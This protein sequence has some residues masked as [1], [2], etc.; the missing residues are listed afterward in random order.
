VRF[1]RI[2]GFTGIEA[3]RDDA[4]RGSLRVVEG[5]LPHGPGGLRSGPVWEKIGEAGNHSSSDSNYISAADDGNGNSLIM[6]SRQ[7]EFRDMVLSSTE[8][9]EIESFQPSYDV[10][11]PEGSIYSLDNAPISSIGNRLYAVGDG[12]DEAIYLGKGP[13]QDG[14]FAVRPDV[15]L[16]R[17][18]WSRF[19]KCKFFARGPKGSLFGAGNPDKPL[20][21]YISEPP[22]ISAPLRDAPYSTEETVYNAGSLSTVEILVSDATKITALSTRGDQVVV[23]TNKGSFL[24]YAP[25]GDQ[26]NTGYRVE[27]VPATN[28]SAAV[29]HQVVAGESGTQTYWIGHDGQVYKDEAASRGAADL[30]SV[31]D[32]DQANWKSKG[33]WEIEIPT[34]I[35]NSFATFEGQTGNYIF[36]L[37]EKNYSDEFSV[38]LAPLNGQSSVEVQ[39]NIHWGIKIDRWNGMNLEDCRWNRKKSC[40]YKTNEPLFDPDWT[41][42]F[43]Y[44]VFATKEEAVEFIGSRRTCCTSLCCHDDYLWGANRND[45]FCDPHNPDNGAPE[46]DTH[47]DCAA[48]IRDDETCENWTYYDCGCYRDVEG[49]VHRDMEERNKMYFGDGSVI[50]KEDPPVSMPGEEACYAYRM[51][52]GCD[53]H[54]LIPLSNT[55]FECGCEPHPSG[56][57]QSLADCQYD[58]EINLSRPGYECFSRYELNYQSCE[59]EENYFGTYATY[60]A[61]ETDNYLR[62]KK[63]DFDSCDP[64]SLNK[65]ECYQTDEGPYQGVDVCNQARSEECQ[66]YDFNC[67]DG[68]QPS[69]NGPFVSLTQCQNEHDVVCRNYTF[70]GCEIGCVEGT[71]HIENAGIMNLYTCTE[72]YNTYCQMHGL[73]V[74]TDSTGLD[75]ECVPDVSGGYLNLGICEEA[76]A[77]ECTSYSLTDCECVQDPDGGFDTLS[78]CEAAKAT[79][80]Q[81][82]DLNSC[83]CEA[84][85]TDAGA[86]DTLSDCEVAKEL[87]CQA[88]SLT[89]CECIPDAVGVFPNLSSCELS[90]HIEC[91]SY[92]L[93]EC[94]CVAEEGGAFETKTACEEQKIID[95]SNYSLNNCECVIDNANGTYSSLAECETAKQSECQRYNLNSFCECVQDPGGAYSTL[96]EC[97][98]VSL[99]TC[100]TYDINRDS[101]ECVPNYS[102]TGKFSDSYACNNERIEKCARHGIDDCCY[103]VHDSFG[104]F[105]NYY[106]CEESLAIGGKYENCDPDYTWNKDDAGCCYELDNCD[107]SGGYIDEASCVA[108]GGK[109]EVNETYCLTTGG[110]ASYDVCN[111]KSTPQD[112]LRYCGGDNPE[113]PDHCDNCPELVYVLSD[114]G[115][116]C[117]PTLS[118]ES[119][120]V[121]GYIIAHE[122]I[123]ECSMTI[124]PACAGYNLENCT[125][126]QTA[127]GSGTYTGITECEQA[128][129]ADQNCVTWNL[130]EGTCE[131]V[132]VTGDVGQ[133]MSQAECETAKSA[134]N[135][136]GHYWIDA[137]TCSCTTT[138]PNDGNPPFV[139]LTNCDN[140]LYAHECM[141]GG[142]GGGGCDDSEYVYQMFED[143]PG[144]LVCLNQYSYDETNNVTE[145]TCEAAGA[146]IFN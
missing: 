92:N 137:N 7:C 98:A 71:E 106:Q 140:A 96:S 60:S 129:D 75:C 43:L 122:T 109:T 120:I 65:G 72:Y 28:F 33:V 34:D 142:G 53:P 130:D 128:R 9:V 136:C 31:A 10:M 41:T 67:T 23:H 91:Q 76:L 78:L 121:S 70:G 66:N 118:D 11:I 14:E 48:T 107:S 1:F 146:T 89:D 30:K 105:E 119:G 26:A 108:S 117:E 125:C 22:G 115:C 80:C 133:Y 2:P 45:C 16:Y 38:P 90:R 50:L 144:E 63:W 3:H 141:T 56:E 81:K 18:E 27:Q 24:L 49:K 126:I 32:E 5:C 97:Q 124:D 39:L 113:Y 62:C 6:V 73:T 46:F 25:T 114:W 112:Y 87:E 57:Y 84:T 15:L 44:R 134:D 35:S 69:E 52:V 138:D 143:G 47:S 111:A 132:S 29:N 40:I 4:D 13:V 20:T 103:C 123:E 83:I 64:S 116:F 17:Q 110:Y 131:C 54:T 61:C 135:Y 101:C 93:T 68:C 19:P 37:E 139:G 104:E 88:Y 55:N 12:S 99:E 51:S 145:C 59:C 8:N 74:G 42:D 85:G 77:E 79:E 58:I 21:V 94:E 102:G 82:Y 127:D 95:C 36:Y 100:L 86:F